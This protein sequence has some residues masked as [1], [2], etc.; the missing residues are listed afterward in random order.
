[1]KICY[2]APPGVH[3]SRWLSYFAD[4]GHDVHL[5]TSLEPSDNID[6][7]KLHLLKRIGP[8]LRVINYLIN[9]VPML[10]QFK[11]LIKSIEP[12]ILHAHYIMETSLLA[13]LGGFHPF[14]VT[15]WG[16]DVLIAPRKSRMSGWVAKFV[17]KRADLVTCDAEHIKEPL[18]GLGADPRKIKLIYFGTDTEKFKPMPKDERLAKELGTPGSPTIISLRRFEPIYNV[19]T[20]I[21]A[22]PL[23]LGEVPEAKFL[24]VERGSQQEMLKGLAES[25]GV[26]S[27]VIFTGLVPPDELP[28]YLNLADIYVSTSLSDA[29]LASSTAEAMAC[30]LP[31]VITDFGDNGKWVQDGVNGFII[32]QKAPQELASKIIALIKDEEMRKRFGKKNRGIITERSDWQ[33]EMAKMGRLYEELAKEA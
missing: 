31:V 8:R 11:S 3:T 1:M 20:L 24:L 14:I 18:T 12:D 4:K 7:V 9:S 17:L 28:R 5:I 26:S 30:G 23:V 6:N 29:G 33:K 2:V 22:V 13:A 32:P 10:L 15:T 27:R 21:R 16:S 25:L 19:E